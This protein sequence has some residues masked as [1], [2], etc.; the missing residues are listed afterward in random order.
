MTGICPFYKALAPSTASS[1]SS[2]LISTS[3]DTTSPRAFCRSRVLRCWRRASSQWASL[4]ILSVGDAQ[5]AGRVEPGPSKFKVMEMDLYGFLLISSYTM[6]YNCWIATLGGV[7]FSLMKSPIIFNL[8][9]YLHFF[10]NL[11]LPWIVKP[12]YMHTTI[13]S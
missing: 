13:D 10:F 8:P 6:L 12:S 1:G 3:G 5:M 7:Y 4:L 9:G 2:V 11:H